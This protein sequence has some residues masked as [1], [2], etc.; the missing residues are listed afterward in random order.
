MTDPYVGT[1]KERAKKRTYA[2]NTKELLE[3]YEKLNP[4]IGYGEEMTLALHMRL[5]RI[6]DVLEE[7]M[8]K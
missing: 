8:N 1:N 2:L 4:Y 3:Y 7:L 5:E 6:E